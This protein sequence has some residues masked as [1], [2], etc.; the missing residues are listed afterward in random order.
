MAGNGVGE[1][2]EQI[3]KRQREKIARLERSAAAWEAGAA[4]ERATGEVLAALDPVEWSVLH[5]VRWPGR[6][7][8]NIDHVVVG[9]GGV[10]VIDSKNWSGKVEVKN[11]VL[12]Q[13]GFSRE[14]EVAGVAESAIAASGSSPTC[15]FNR[16]CAWHVTSRSTAGCGTSCCARPIILERCWR[17]GRPCFRLTRPAG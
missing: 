8:A 12:R 6:A 13:N 17:H 3:A 15:R 2:A 10:F 7:R 16:C 14:K 9:L 11:G 1:S 5:D 4:G